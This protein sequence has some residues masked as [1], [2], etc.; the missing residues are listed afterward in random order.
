MS[1]YRTNYFHDE[2]RAL[3]FETGKSGMGFT[4][5]LML[6][7]RLS[8]ACTCVCNMYAVSLVVVTF[9][10]REFTFTAIINIKIYV[11]SLDVTEN[12]HCQ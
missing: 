12:K 7:R 1:N 3:E 9:Y 8:N 5:H 6:V 4:C 10:Y 11:H 2:R